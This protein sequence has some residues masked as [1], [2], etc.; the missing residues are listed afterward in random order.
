MGLHNHPWNVW[1]SV[2]WNVLRSESSPGAESLQ[3]AVWQVTTSEAPYE[4][5]ILKLG[6]HPQEATCKH[7]GTQQ[8]LQK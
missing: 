4:V 7:V 2:V 1:P 6:C 5:V 8:Q 3:G